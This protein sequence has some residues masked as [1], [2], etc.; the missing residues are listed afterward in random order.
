MGE[1]KRR[2]RRKGGVRKEWRKKALR[3][4]RILKDGEEKSDRKRVEGRGE[5]ATK[6]KGGGRS[7]EH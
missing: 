6:V 2:Q 1:G 7:G 5:K 4:E 3:R